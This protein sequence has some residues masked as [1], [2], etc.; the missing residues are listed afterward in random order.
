MILTLD[1]L[2]ELINVPSSITDAYL[3]IQLKNTALEIFK[4]TN[5]AYLVTETTVAGYCKFV[6]ATGPVYT[7]EVPY[8]LYLQPGVVWVENS[9]LN[10]N[11]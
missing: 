10:D 11:L 2:K 4:F 5:K 6:A 1:E 9:I 8:N 7:I 3:N